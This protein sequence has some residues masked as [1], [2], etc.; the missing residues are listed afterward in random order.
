MVERGQPP[1]IPVEFSSRRHAD[2]PVEVL[3]RREIFSRVDQAR[4]RQ[5]ER[6][7]FHA[8]M[9]MRSDGGTHTV[10]FED[11]RARSGRLLW[12]R[13]G[14]VQAW[15]TTADFEATLVL[16]RPAAPVVDPWFPGDSV[17]CDLDGDERALAEGLIG[18]IDR[19]QSS[20]IGSR[21]RR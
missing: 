1:I 3:E 18:G 10:D 17:F 14:Q 11:I 8:L 19:E 12:F 2:L 4:L 9:L 20:F 5:P 16:S 15:S 13:P 7:A 21:H 6:L